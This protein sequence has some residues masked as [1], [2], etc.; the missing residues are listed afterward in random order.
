M[1]ALNSLPRHAGIDTDREIL[2]LVLNDAPHCRSRDRD[3]RRFDRAGHLHFTAVAGQRDG[4]LVTRGIEQ[5][6]RQF[7]RIARFEH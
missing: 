7:G 4:A 2:G 6:F 3:I 5:G 1:A